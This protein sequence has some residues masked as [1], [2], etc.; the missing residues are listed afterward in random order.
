[1]S[2]PVRQSNLFAAED[3]LKVYRSFKDVDF[4]AYDFDTIRSALVEYIQ[5]QYPEDFNDFI[6][7]SEFIAIIELLSYLGT[8][9]ALRTDLNSRENF[10]DTAERRES[11]IRLAR[12]LSYSPKRN[13]PAKGLFKITG[14]STN[15]PVTDSAG[16][17]L[18][19]TTIF[20]NDQNNPD[21]FE[22]FITVLN[23]AFVSINQFGRPSKSGTISNIPTDLYQINSSVPRNPVDSLSLTIPSGSIPWNVVNPDFKDGENFFERHPDPMKPF[24][25]I[26]RN[27]SL[28]LDSNNTGFFLFLKQGQM[29]NRVYELDFP[30]KN[31]VLDIEGVTGVNQEDV[32]YQEIN[33]N[34]EVLSE[35]TRVPALVGNNVI[36]NSLE[37]DIREIFNVIS[38]TDDAIQLKF[39]DGNFGDIPRGLYRLWFRSS[40]GKFFTLNPDDASNLSLRIP[41]VAKNGQEYILTVFYE[42]QESISNAVPSETNEQ[43]K[44]NAP[45]VFYTQN[46]MVNAEDYNVYPL[47]RGNEITKVRAINRTHAGH[48]R[49]IDINDPTGI[50][51][52]V[53]LFAEDGALY[54]EYEPERIAIDVDVSTDY[55]EIINEDLFDFLRNERVINHFYDQYYK[56]YLDLFPNALDFDSLDYIWS[57]KPQTNRSA[58]G[59]FADGLDIDYNQEWELV[60]NGSSGIWTLQDEEKN[61]SSGAASIPLTNTTD[62]TIEPVENITSDDYFIQ[63]KRIQF[64]SSYEPPVAPV[65]GLSARLRVRFREPINLN[66]TENILI[67]PGA[68]LFFYNPTFPEQKKVVSVKGVR[69]AGL[70]SSESLDGT[71]PVELSSFIPDGWKLEKILPPW[72]TELQPE[73]IDD[74]LEQLELQNDF[75]LFYDITNHPYSSLG[76]VGE[77]KVVT[78]DIIDLGSDLDDDNFN[79]ESA[80]NPSPGQLNA[81]WLIYLDFVPS[82]E[83]SNNNRYDF[84]SRGTRYVFESLNEVRFFY[85]AEQRALD[86]RTGQERRDQIVI[87]DENDKPT[88]VI[89]ENWILSGQTWFLEQ[90]DFLNPKQYPNSVGIVLPSNERSAYTITTN[91]AD[92]DEISNLDIDDRGTLITSGALTGNQY[93]WVQGSTI[94]IEY[95]VDQGNLD[96][97]IFWDVYKSYL[98]EDG[99]LDQTKI[100]VR[101]QDKDEDGIPDNPLSFDDFVEPT[102]FIFFEQYTDFDGYEYFRPW[103]TGYNT[104][105]GDPNRNMID[106]VNEQYN[107]FDINKTG[108]FIFGTRSQLQQFI[109]QVENPNNFLLPEDPIFSDDFEGGLSDREQRQRNFAQL[110]EGKYVYVEQTGFFYKIPLIVPPDPPSIPALEYNFGRFERDFTHFRRNG[111]TVSLNT[112]DEEDIPLWFQW[113]H[114]SPLENRIDPSVS[115]II[116]MYILTS[117]YYNQ[118]LVWKEENK[119][120]EDLP[121]PPTTDDLT[122]QFGDLN[123]FK[124]LSDQIIYQPAKFKIMFGEQAPIEYR[125]TFKVVKLPSTLFSDSEIKSRVVQ[126]IDQYFDV[127]NWDFGESFYYTELAAYIH[128]QLSTIIASVVVVPEKSESQFGDLFQ[129]KSEPNELFFSTAKV[130]NIEIIES[131]TDVNLRL[132]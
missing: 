1:M 91:F 76:V 69:N 67:K 47:E 33:D 96:E 60:W 126:A 114:F 131:L 66:L 36:F 77:W 83:T 29:D 13:I 116:D 12:M 44:L 54:K 61:V 132:K 74:I 8:S 41:Y 49:F 50:I 108:L 119:P 39:A 22:Q 124:M 95:N 19:Q 81:G 58:T 38:G 118:V 62:F 130:Q 107:G 37:L 27:D 68:I 82:V 78:S 125:A 72:R 73:E 59:Y 92:N 90:V 52:N 84:L 105:E 6:E 34:G 18:S 129:V 14:V 32:Y 88:K 57:T 46:R 55:E 104:I 53:K 127:K 51:Q 42:L 11:V 21:S 9:L 112:F 45:A 121:E 97:H 2:G 110:L 20:W 26:Y 117:S 71:G 79:L 86:N 109:S 102:D 43:I 23:A 99:Y 93:D 48:S 94:T 87:L 3:F 128:Q 115:N 89:T 56:Q 65:N 100:E 85:S 5:R 106:F 122:V 75:G 64:Y 113:K 10:L 30:I 15:E 40:L 101:P 24:H 63:F 120:I 111:R 7:S 80:L 28:G 103:I 16:R 123:N 25:L 31:R 17:N 35:W 98:L 4:T 70:P